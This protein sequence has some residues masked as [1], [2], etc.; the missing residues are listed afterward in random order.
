MGIKDSNLVSETEGV[1][2]PV[3]IAIKKFKEHPSIKS[4]NENNLN[5]TVFTFSAIT[6]TDVEHE[7]NCLKNK[8]GTFKNISTKIL[9]ETSDICSEALVNIWNDELIHGKRFPT[10]LKLADVTPI[11][12]KGDA[13]LTKNY[14]PV[15]VLP[16]I[17]KIFERL[18]LKQIVSYIEKFLSPYL[19]GYRKGFSTQTALLSLI[20]RWKITLDNKGYAGAI[21]MDLSKAAFDSY[22]LSN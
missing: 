1:T 5:T 10:S 17:S 18:M 16:T 21:L 14:R 19:C 12:K 8:T 7:I 6:V 20:E 4:I 9:K 2:D 11:F 3:D 22:L 15:S 13:T